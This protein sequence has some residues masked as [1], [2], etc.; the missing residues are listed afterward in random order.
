MCSFLPRSAVYE[1][2]GRV[3]F[4]GCKAG[5]ALGEWILY[6]LAIFAGVWYGWSMALLDGDTPSICVLAWVSMRYVSC[7]REAEGN[8]KM[9]VPFV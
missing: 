9:R 8:V 2:D 1:L 6:P 7:T 5:I 4:G 3:R